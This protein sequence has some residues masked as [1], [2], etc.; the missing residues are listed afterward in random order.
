MP[1]TSE[2]SI[3]LN[4]ISILGSPSLH[5]LEIT[6]EGEVY[7]RTSDG[8]RIIPSIDSIV[9]ID[10]K[11]LCLYD[12]GWFIQNLKDDNVFLNMDLILKNKI[13]PIKNKQILEVK[14]HQFEISFSL[15]PRVEE[16]GQQTLTELLSEPSQYQEPETAEDP[17]S[18][19]GNS[20]SSAVQRRDT[21]LEHLDILERLE[22]EYQEVIITP[23]KLNT[24]YGNIKMNPSN[25]EEGT[26]P[27][28]VGK[29]LSEIPVHDVVVGQLTIKDV[30]HSLE[31]LN[32]EQLFTEEEPV[33]VLMLFAPA[34]TTAQK[35]QQH[36]FPQMTQKDH[37]YNSLNS[38]MSLGDAHTIKSETDTLIK[39]EQS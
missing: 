20:F 24:P 1:N 37:R 29:K 2:N 9:L 19:I 31:G 13:Y 39:E 5:Q 18:V 11:M 4:I 22:Q 6:K 16:V 36:R 23:E 10:L 28:E 8:V 26:D 12:K 7:Q 38:P 34:Q 30:E 21:D 3:Y 25:K 14:E 15:N 33:D 35:N 17:F 27:F 32:G